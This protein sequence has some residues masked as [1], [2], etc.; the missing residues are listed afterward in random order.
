MNGEETETREPTTLSAVAVPT[1]LLGVNG[2]LTV[3]AI[4][5]PVALL[6]VGSAAVAG[7]VGCIA[8]KKA[9]GRR[10][11]FR[12]VAGTARRAMKKVGA[13]HRPKMGSSAGKSRLPNASSGKSGFWGRK[14]TGRKLATAGRKEVA[15][16]KS[17]RDRNG[18]K[19]L[20]G[21]KR[22]KGDLFSSRPSASGRTAGQLGRTNMFNSAK[23]AKKSPAR[24]LRTRQVPWKTV[25]KSGAALGRAG[26]GAGRR[27][28]S[29]EASKARVMKAGIKYALASAF[30]FTQKLAKSISAAGRVLKRRFG[31]HLKYWKDQQKAATDPISNR[32]DADVNHTVP[33]ILVHAAPAAMCAL[34]V[35]P[36]TRQTTHAGSTHMSHHPFQSTIE[37]VRADFARFQPNRARDVEGYLKGLTE[38]FE[39]F[40]NGLMVGG[41]R[42]NEGFPIDP[43]AAEYITGLGSHIHS[44]KTHVEDAS[45]SFHSAH[46]DQF[47]RINSG[48]ERQ[49][50]WDYAANQD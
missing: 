15:A 39:E 7:T 8:A 28:A 21:G 49:R 47:E 14:V 1:G 24:G 18:P 10:Q 27:L 26:L 6:A 43:G 31:K 32:I 41:S 17:A 33:P 45:T 48:D 29:R 3:G 11:A 9:T 5:G 13:L 12:T 37:A 42:I 16:S 38:V 23:R 2:L 22:K 34:P 44:V 4:F 36:P 30:P 19:A 35:R 20:A 46:A 50:A 25:R 40:G